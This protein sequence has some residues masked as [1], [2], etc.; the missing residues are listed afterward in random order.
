MH[1][2]YKALVVAFNSFTNFFISRNN[3]TPYPF[4][5]RGVIIGGSSPI[6][7]NYPSLRYAQEGASRGKA[8]K[9]IPLKIK[10]VRT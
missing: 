8:K 5:D 4:D 10:K 2:T 9:S 1:G 3:N 7:V 6:K